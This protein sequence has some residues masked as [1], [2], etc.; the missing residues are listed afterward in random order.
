[1]TM[2]ELFSEYLE[3]LFGGRRAEARELLFAAQDRGVTS[4]KMLKTVIWPA[5][6]QVEK[7]YKK[8]QIPRITEHMATR[9]NRLLAD[10]L[11]GFMRR[12]P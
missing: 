6:E 9:I 3:H 7:L 10:Q 4:T 8:N 11:Q 5:M 1:M 2:A 12:E